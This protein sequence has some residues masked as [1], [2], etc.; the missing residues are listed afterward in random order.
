MV[1]TKL[2]LRLLVLGG[3]AN[4]RLLCFV[5]LT[6][7][8]TAARRAKQREARDR[9]RE[10]TVLSATA[11]PG[12]VIAIQTVCKSTQTRLDAEVLLE[13][14][15]MYWDR[16]Q[17]RNVDIADK[18]VQFIVNERSAATRMHLQTH[19]SVNEIS[20]TTRTHLQTYQSDH[21]EP[22]EDGD[23]QYEDYDSYEDY[24]VEDKMYS[25][26][27]SALPVVFTGDGSLEEK[28]ESTCSG[29]TVCVLD[30]LD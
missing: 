9:A 6:V 23:C 7:M 17:R 22:G 25:D 21:A 18:L 2:F 3:L 27:E 12:Q 28:V 24:D 4:W 26:G 5:L 30:A 19:Q 8:P 14:I 20:S 1:S 15:R 29:N 10:R 11:A 16:L 13:L